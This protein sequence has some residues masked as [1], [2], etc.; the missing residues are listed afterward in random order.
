MPTSVETT[1]KGMN[2]LK[3]DFYIN[4]TPRITNKSKQLKKGLSRQQ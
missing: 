3:P 1:L 2:K 4:N